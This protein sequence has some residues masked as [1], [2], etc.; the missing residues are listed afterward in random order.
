[1]AWRIGSRVWYIILYITER[2]IIHMAHKVNVVLDDD[3]TGALERMVESGRRSRVINDALRKELLAMRRARA[4]AS[5]DSL[6]SATPT[7]STAD[8]VDTL[9]RDRG[10]S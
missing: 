2:L 9:R 8:I 3:V 10:R 4:V 1:M 5:M 7:S 6:R